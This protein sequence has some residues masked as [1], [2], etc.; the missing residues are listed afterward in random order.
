MAV[1]I[2]SVGSY[3]VNQVRRLSQSSGSISVRSVRNSI[4]DINTG[5]CSGCWKGLRSQFSKAWQ[6]VRNHL[7]CTAKTAVNEAQLSDQNIDDLFGLA[8]TE[9][10]EDLNAL[11]NRVQ[12]LKDSIGELLTERA[13]IYRK[14]RKLERC[15]PRLHRQRLQN[16]KQQR[17]DLDQAI[18]K[19]MVELQEAEASFAVNLLAEIDTLSISS[20][21]SIGSEDSNEPEVLESS[22]L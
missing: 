11:D 1:P 5:C 12:E 18:N 4:E 22:Q 2:G 19:K 21:S 10:Q 14:I 20:D 7:C 15:C 6:W 3:A 9:P 13:E 17:H 8:D 16:L